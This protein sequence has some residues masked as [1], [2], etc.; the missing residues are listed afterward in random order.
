MAYTKYSLT[1]ANNN[2]APP[3]GAPEGMLP[4]A[5]NDTMR[6]MM[7][8]I[9]DCGD[10]IRGGTY[11]MTAPVITGGSINGTTTITTSGA[12][13]YT[14]TLTGGTGIVNLGSGQ[15][16][17]DASGNVGLGTASPNSKIQIN[18]S[19]ASSNSIAQFTNGSTGSAA[20]NGLY[21][22]VDTSNDATIFNFFNSNLKF[23]T[24]GAERMRITGGGDLLVGLTSLAS[25]FAGIESLNY[26][27]SRGYATRAGNPGPYGGNTFNLNWTG[28]A[29]Q[30]WIDNTNLGTISTSSDY[31]I[32]K[33]IKTQTAPALERVMALRPVTYQMANYGGLYKANEEI[34]EGFIAH[35]VQEVIPSGAEGVKDDENQIQSL[36]VDAILAVAIKAIQEL[37]AEVQALKQQLG[38]K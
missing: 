15:F 27:S 23:G 34:K 26:V 30:A 7:S 2:A 38:A 3:D 9:R 10:G 29:L 1:P 16:Y 14:G 18:N 35:E 6:D 21:V 5:V 33:N 4:S 22:G 11:T 17:K 25:G 13:S 36:R 12:I 20:G 32:K 28:S 37:N 19:T 24:N 31:R 8:Q